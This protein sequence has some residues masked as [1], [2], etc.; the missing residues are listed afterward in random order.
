[1]SNCQPGTIIKG[2][3]PYTDSTGKKERYLL[4]LTH[5]DELN[6]VIVVK[7]S[8]RLYVTKYGFEL[9]DE[10][11]EIPL[12]YKSM[13]FCNKI[14]TICLNLEYK[15]VSKIKDSYFQQILEIIRSIFQ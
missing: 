13:I 6:D 10:M 2:N 7:I 14:G 3:F 9:T 8:S 4:I 12:P 1:M 15:V 11:L 5:P